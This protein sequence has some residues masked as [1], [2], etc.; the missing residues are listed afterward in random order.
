MN[1]SFQGRATGDPSASTDD[2]CE[3]IQAASCKLRVFH[4]CF[5]RF[6]RICRRFGGPK[7]LCVSHF[8]TG[9]SP[10]S[11]SAAICAPTAAIKRHPAAALYDVVFAT[12]LRGIATLAQHKNIS[13]RP[14]EHEPLL[15]HALEHVSRRT[16]RRMMKGDPDAEL[17][18]GLAICHSL[19]V[20]SAAKMIGTLEA[21]Q[22]V[23]SDAAT[24]VARAE[25]A[26]KPAF[27]NDKSPTIRIWPDLAAIA[28]EYYRRENEV[29][30]Q[31]FPEVQGA[32]TRVSVTKPN[33]LWTDIIRA[34]TPARET[35]VHG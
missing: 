31:I 1:Y 27:A 17:M 34:A 26:M 33:Q 25:E 35:L 30:E 2:V 3:Q 6:G 7:T 8:M 24:L 15:R 23:V 20:F 32:A 5:D 9:V 18:V 12:A 10:H 14:D 19:D 28:E 21:I 11:A 22:G 16:M 29:S 13:L 4:R